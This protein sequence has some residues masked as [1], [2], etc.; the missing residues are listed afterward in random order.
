[1][2]RT[3]VHRWLREDF[4]FQAAYNRLRRELQRELEARLDRAVQAAAATVCA[5]VEAGDLRASLAVLRG[6]GVLSEARAPIGSEDA[7]ELEDETRAEAEA[8]AAARL[9]RRIGV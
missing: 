4:A 9:L 1:M 6:S 5:A 8:R 7:A 3:S 2:D